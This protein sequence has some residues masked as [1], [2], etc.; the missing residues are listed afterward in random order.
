MKRIIFILV[1]L[2][3]ITHLVY[4]SPKIGAIEILTGK[5]T[6]YKTVLSDEVEI[7][8]DPGT[9]Y[10]IYLDTGLGKSISRIEGISSN[11]YKFNRFYLKILPLEAYST[12]KI[13]FREDP[14]VRPLIAVI[15]GSWISLSSP[16]SLKANSSYRLSFKEDRLYAV[17]VKLTVLSKHYSLIF[18]GSSYTVVY[19]NSTKIEVNGVEISATEV[20]LVLYGDLLSIVNKD[21]DVVLF[22]AYRKF[23]Y[24]DVT[25]GSFLE[26]CFI[27]YDTRLV[28]LK[29][30]GTYLDSNDPFIEEK[31]PAPLKC[32]KVEKAIVEE[33]D[34]KERLVE[35]RA[36][37]SEGNFIEDA[38]IEVSSSESA[39]RAKGKACL[40]TADLQLLVKVYLYG[41]LS[42]EYLVSTRSSTLD[43]PLKL[44]QISL[45]VVDNNMIPIDKA[46]V[47]LY[48]YSS[49]IAKNATVVNGKAVFKNIPA[50][51]YLVKVFYGNKEVARKSITVKH[52]IQEIVVCS[53]ADLKIRVKDSESLPVPGVKIIL[54]DRISGKKV[55]EGVTDSNGEVCFEKIV[56]GDYV[57]VL[58]Y[59]FKNYTFNI[60]H[61][62]KFIELEIPLKSVK[63]LLF[64]KF[65]NSIKDARV[66][67]YYGDIKIAEASPDERGIVVFSKI[68]E[69]EYTLKILCIGGVE[70]KTVKIVSKSAVIAIYL[71]VVSVFGKPIK[72]EILKAGLAIFAGLLFLVFVMKVKKMV[73]KR[74]KIKPKKV[75]IVEE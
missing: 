62:N 71:D 9:E 48:S 20:G 19:E 74:R 12:V 32:I 58:Q 18:N 35:L 34:Y 45:E 37:D 4:G 31:L 59:L 6:T 10:A 47:Q 11:K 52:S 75:I 25:E 5:D 63:I 15:P 42:G 17:K 61:N 49:L 29:L 27:I 50:G 68:P 22:I 7:Q 38:V 36:V 56:Y 40:K 28:N 1:S 39:F 64:D 46:V 60:V 70:E 44:Y 43:I 8:L 24:K 54:F 53:L 72:T 65:S 16:I 55:C 51:V 66:E 3:L 13:L 23:Y 41:T 14:L 67:L 30:N 33:I 73:S 57:A 2:I 69:G 21:Q 26:K